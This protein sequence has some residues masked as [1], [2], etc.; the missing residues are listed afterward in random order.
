[1]YLKMFDII[2]R[3]YITSY[4]NKL[5]S[6]IYLQVKKRKL[7]DSVSIFNVALASCNIDIVRLITFIRILLCSI[8]FYN[9][10]QFS[11]Q[12]SLPCKMPGILNFEICFMLRGPNEKYK[13]S[14]LTHFRKCYHFKEKDAKIIF[15]LNFSV[16]IGFMTKIVIIYFVENKITQNFYLQYSFVLLIDNGLYSLLLKVHITYY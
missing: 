8:I 1:M 10:Q 12:V 9:C 3:Y 16:S 11:C 7:N 5:L 6:T 4:N 15:F 13:F 14:T 2:F